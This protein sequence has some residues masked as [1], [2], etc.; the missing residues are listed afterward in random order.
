[1]R[2]ETPRQTRLTRHELAD[3]LNTAETDGGPEL[4]TR[5]VRLIP[6]AMT[7]AALGA[8]FLVPE[9]STG[10][11]QRFLYG[12]E[13]SLGEALMTFVPIPPAIAATAV[14]ASAGCR[15]DELHLI[16]SSPATV[17]TEARG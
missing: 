17:I 5:L 13:A 8:A 12:A 16:G 3:W 7:A 10:A 6:V 9:T 14:M 15:R 11:L 1:V 4:G 2:D